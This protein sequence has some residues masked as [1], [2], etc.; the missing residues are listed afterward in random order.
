MKITIDIP[1]KIVNLAAA[2]LAVELADAEAEEAVDYAVR[3]LEEGTFTTD[4][5]SIDEGNT[6]LLAL[7]MLAIATKADEYQRNEDDKTIAA[8]REKGLGG[9]A[10]RL[11]QMQEER[12]RIM[13]EQRKNG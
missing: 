12:E 13:K 7:A 4:F 1:K 10:D 9:L 2:T 11:K 6:M 8:V 3:A 5:K